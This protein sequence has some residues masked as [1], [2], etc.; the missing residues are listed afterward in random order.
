MSA[1]PVV[2]DRAAWAVEPRDADLVAQILSGDS[3]AYRPLVQRYQE[4]LFRY[5]MGMVGNADAASDLVQDAM[6][7]AYGSLAH[8]RAPDQFGAWLSRI[9]RNKCLDYLKD[10][11]RSVVPLHTVAEMDAGA[12]PADLRLEREEVRNAVFQALAVLPDEQR[13]AFLLKHVEERSYEEMT[14]I[15]G[16]SISA[17]K[18]R[19]KRAREALQVMLDGKPL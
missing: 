17:L 1:S 5:A 16:A 19:V 10:R 18:M 11:R 13:E 6:I 3:E 8:C 7:K 2:R 4:P 15:V 14:E 12:A 9:L